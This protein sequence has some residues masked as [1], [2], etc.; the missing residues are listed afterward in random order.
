MKKDIAT[1][2]ELH[3]MH[4]LTQRQV[5]YI[6]KNH[7]PYDKMFGSKSLA[8]KFNVSPQTITNIVN[9]KNWIE[10]LPYAKELICNE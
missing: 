3:G 10:T 5:D 7:K 2:G 6:R 8:K 9:Y 4:K 1:K